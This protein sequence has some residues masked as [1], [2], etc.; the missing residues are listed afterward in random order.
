MWHDDLGALVSKH[1]TE[2]FLDHH[3]FPGGVL[4]SASQSSKS[5]ESLWVV[6]DVH[7]VGPNYDK[8]SL[9]ILMLRRQHGG[10]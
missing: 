5:T 10:S 3:T 9:Q 2:R 6:E 7:D 1:H 4:P 8:Q